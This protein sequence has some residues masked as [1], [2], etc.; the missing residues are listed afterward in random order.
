MSNKL[1]RNMSVEESVSIRGVRRVF[2]NYSN[3]PFDQ[4]HS[5]KEIYEIAIGK[6]PGNQKAANKAFEELAIVAGNA[7]A[8]ALTLVDGLVV[9][10]GG[11]S[12]AWPVFL[13]CLVEELTLPF[14]TFSG[15]NIDRLEIK[16]FNLEDG[17]QRELFLKGSTR[18]I[19]IPGSARK[20]TYDPEH[21]SGVGITRLGTSRATALGAYNFALRKLDSMK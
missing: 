18:K 10:G 21:R 2:S 7:I 8:D 3:I 6:R 1:Y 19:E 5:P 17:A 9:I 15:Q 12:G 11:L 20:I 4:T 16:F 13:N 14:T